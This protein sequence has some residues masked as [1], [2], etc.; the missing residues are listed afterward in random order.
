MY[1]KFNHL[2]LMQGRLVK[3]EKKKRIQ[4]FPAKNWKKEIDLMNDVKINI[5]EW[6]INRENAKIIH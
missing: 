5:L 6:T 1:F 4:Y 2:G 3:S